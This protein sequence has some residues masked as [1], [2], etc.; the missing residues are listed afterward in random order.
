M[1]RRPRSRR[2]RG[3]RSACGKACAQAVEDRLVGDLAGEPHIARRNLRSIAGDISARRQCDGVPEK[4]VTPCAAEAS[5][6]IGD[7]LRRRSTAR[8]KPRRAPRARKS[9]GRHSGGCHRT[10]PRRRSRRPRSRLIGAVRPA[11][12]C[13]TIFG[14]PVV[15]EV[16]STHSVSN[17]PAAAAVRPRRFRRCTRRG[18][19]DRML[20]CRAELAIDDHGVDLGA[21]TMAAKW[22]GS[23]SGGRMAIRRAT[24]SS[25][26]RASAARQLAAGGD[27]DRLVRQARRAGR[28][29]S[30]RRSDRRRRAR[31]SRSEE[32]APRRTDA[33][34][35]RLRLSA[36]H[37][38]RLSRSR[39][40]SRETAHLPTP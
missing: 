35:Q 39:R 32:M 40:K 31:A 15:P 8:A 4:W 3:R 12:V 17:A 11:S 19:E 5:E 33:L 24:P 38:H 2:R 37:F 14:T 29:G 16:S 23:A 22:S 13:T 28:R 9:A 27:E 26:I 7:R 30:C 1:R 34:P 25:S 18:A 36:R 21:A 20:R 10:C 6:M